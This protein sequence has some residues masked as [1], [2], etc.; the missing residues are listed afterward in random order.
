M[1]PWA[2]PP[3][4]HP[5]YASPT[6]HGYAP[7]APSMSREEELSYLKEQAEAIK[8]ELERIEA[9]VRELESQS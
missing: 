8:E 5:Y 4:Y 3:V 9:R 2:Y 6:F 7:F 1:T